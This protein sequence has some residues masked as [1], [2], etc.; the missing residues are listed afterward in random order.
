M[1]QLT[2]QPCTCRRGKHG[3]KLHT[4]YLAATA[5][6]AST[7]FRATKLDDHYEAQWVDL[8][9]AIQLPASQLHPLLA[10]VLSSENRAAL[11]AAFG[12]QL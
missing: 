12:V 4:V 7:G 2:R 9:E 6:G 1:T 5:A 8:K 3:I 11:S 10:E